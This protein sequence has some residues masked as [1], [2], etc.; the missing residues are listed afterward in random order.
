MKGLPEFLQ[1]F[2]EAAQKIRF[3]ALVDSLGLFACNP[4]TVKVKPDLALL[5]CF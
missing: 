2:G 1:I 3:V 5:S 4:L